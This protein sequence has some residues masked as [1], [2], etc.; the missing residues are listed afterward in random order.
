VRGT[1]DEAVT[2]HNFL[3]YPGKTGTGEVN[4]YDTVNLVRQ[5]EETAGD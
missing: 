2:C 1:D 4:I 3:A 5:A